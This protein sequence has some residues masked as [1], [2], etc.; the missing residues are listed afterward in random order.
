MRRVADEVELLRAV[1]GRR[2]RFGAQRGQR[3]ISMKSE[4]TRMNREL[5]SAWAATNGIRGPRMIKRIRS[6]W[7]VAALMAGLL[8]LLFAFLPL[9]A[10]PA[11][12]NSTAQAVYL[13]PTGVE[14][15]DESNGSA[16]WATAQSNT[17]SNSV[18]LDAGTVGGTNAGRIQIL[19]DDPI[20]IA[21]FTG[22]TYSVWEPA[23]TEHGGVYPHGGPELYPFGDPYI[24]ILLDTEG[25]GLWSGEKLEGLAS[26]AV[27]SATSS[28]HSGPPAETWTEM[29]EGYG[30]HDSDD[31]LPGSSPA[32]QARWSPLPLGKLG[33]RQTQLVPRSLGFR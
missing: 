5:R 26:I 16:D 18:L 27:G 19:L 14:L 28:P 11:E 29:E 23:G 30:F 9:M 3:E 25:D 17:G 10:A 8:A 20:P 1:V 33:S 2:T 7:Q 12:A 6:G 13:S 31:S 22:A 24:N 15:I 32:T 21:D 4:A